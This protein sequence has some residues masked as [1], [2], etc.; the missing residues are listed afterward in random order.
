MKTL[1]GIDTPLTA[2]AFATKTWEWAPPAGAFTIQTDWYMVACL[3]FSF[4]RGRLI[5]SPDTRMEFLLR[6][7]ETSYLKLHLRHLIKVIIY[8]I[9]QREPIACINFLNHPYF[10]S[11]EWMASFED[12]LRA[13]NSVDINMDTTLEAN[14]AV[15]FQGNFIL[16]FDRRLHPFIVSSLERSEKNAERNRLRRGRQSHQT[17]SSGSSYSMPL[18]ISLS[19]LE[20]GT[21]FLH[22]WKAIRNRRYHRDEDP[23]LAR[24][25]MGTIPIE[26][27][28]YWVKIFPYFFLY[29]FVKVSNYDVGLQKLYYLPEFDYYFPGDKNFYGACCAVSIT[30]TTNW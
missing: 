18:A 15:V 8:I 2:A 30:E 4:Y 3:M 13:Y 16:L 19:S 20:L 29:L 6:D 1:T 9:E 14:K 17:S 25:I 27:F 22:L 12:R 23:L 11:A 10:A 26:N 7:R 24:Q 5:T 28:V 21:T